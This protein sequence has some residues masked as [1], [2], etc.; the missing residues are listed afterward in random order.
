MTTTLNAPDLRKTPP[1]SGSVTLG[2]FPWLARLADKARAEHAGTQ[3]T[4]EAY[5]EVSKGFLQ[6]A[7]IGIG[8]FSS[9][10]EKGATDED[11]QR[12]FETHVDERH[13]AEAAAWIA[14]HSDEIRDGDIT[15][16]RAWGRTAGAVWKGKVR[17]GEGTVQL[18][19]ST[20]PY[21]FETRFGSKPGSTPEELL[22]AAHAACF[23]MALSLILG[24]AGHVPREIET[25]AR[26]TIERE[27]EG[28]RISGSDLECT[29]DIPG[30]GDTEFQRLVKAA[31]QGCP[32]S[33]ALAGV[34]ITVKASL[35]AGPDC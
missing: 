34:E 22:G 29:A 31:K 21:S 32:V 13:R 8:E 4:Y 3:G 35:K 18:A 23:S 25:K 24:K 12:Y 14:D 26:V 7:G 16:G 2:G 10:I 20:L 5:C 27:G 11:L 30:I 19:G 1:R 9:L 17:D 28:F 6:H 15:E 33:R